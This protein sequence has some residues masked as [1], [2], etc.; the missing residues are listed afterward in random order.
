MNFSPSP[1]PVAN[2][3]RAP[4]IAMT[5]TRTVH[6]TVRLFIRFPFLGDFSGR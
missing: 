5:M 1:L 3:G 2:T 6:R 4:A